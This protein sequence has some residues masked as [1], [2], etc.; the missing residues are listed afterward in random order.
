MNCKTYLAH[1]L[2]GHPDVMV[3]VG[4]RYL[5][6]NPCGLGGT[7]VVLT[8]DGLS[9]RD[10]EPW[11]VG[12]TFD[13][14]PTLQ[15]LAAR[16]AVQAV[17]D[18]AGGAAKVIERSAAWGEHNRA[19]AGKGGRI[20]LTWDGLRYAAGCG[21]LVPLVTAVRRGRGR[22]GS[23][24]A[25]AEGGEEKANETGGGLGA[26]ARNEGLDGGSGDLLS[27]VQIAGL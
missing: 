27:V 1:G 14:S 21:Q 11:A 24:G 18:P 20:V 22:R 5:L 19:M 10:G 26:R 13:P 12:V 7:E 3:C 6:T 23:P 25:G 16:L 4:R 9:I 2:D 15:W 8:V 17:C